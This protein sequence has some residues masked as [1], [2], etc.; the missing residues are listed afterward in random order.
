MTASL[1][2]LF[3]KTVPK[4]EVFTKDQCEFHCRFL[5]FCDTFLSRVFDLNLI[6]FF[7]SRKLVLGKISEVK[8]NLTLLKGGLLGSRSSQK[9]EYVARNE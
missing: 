6:F 1:G 2:C 4:N 9:D 8:V 5:N 7:Q 3:R